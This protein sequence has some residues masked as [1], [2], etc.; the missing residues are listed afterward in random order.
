MHAP[1]IPAVTEVEFAGAAEQAR[2]LRAGAISAPE[3]LERHLD[4]IERLDRA[5]NAFRTVLAASARAEARAAQARLDAGDEAPLLGVPVAVKDN[6]DVAG[7]QSL[8]G[9]AAVTRVA[10]AD[11]EAVRRLRAAGAVIIGKTHLCELAAQPFT[12]SAA[13]GITRNPWDRSRSS[14]GSSGGSA[15]A[16]AAG[17]AAAAL[18]TDGGGSIRIPAAACGVFGLKP[19]R[20]RVSLAPDSEHW[21]GLTVLGPVTRRVDDAALLLDV[22]A[23]GDFAHDARRDPGRLRIGLA[24]KPQ[25]TGVRV[26]RGARDALADAGALLR[27][28]GHT[29]APVTPTYPKAPGVV[30]ARMLAGIADDADR[31]EH[32]ARLERR[33][34]TLA[35]WGRRARRRALPR[36]L[37]AE[38]TVR[39]RLAPLFAEHDVIV[40][41]MFAQ[42]LP[43]AGRWVRAGAVRTFLGVSPWVAYT[44]VWNATGQPA[45]TVPLGLGKDGLPVAVQLVGEAGDERT[46]LA[47]AGQ[48]ER[49]R[50]WADRRPAHARAT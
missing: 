46:L 2:L 5:L 33:T 23:D 6:L 11:C 49:A 28:L 14:G 22:L 25:L 40:T 39:A 35:R 36:A 20:G 34:R 45:A 44:A 30:L 43:R 8:H 7:E 29:V 48:I 13:H 47:L 17:L 18:G 41:P 24:V 31:A 15:V 32:P 38:E 21:H 26:A 50:P 27:A 3:L 12:E 10:A 4:R 37:R 9:S 42:P 19:Q 16:V 1:S